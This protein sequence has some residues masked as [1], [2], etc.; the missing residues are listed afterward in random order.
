MRRDSPTRA[1]SPARA[2]ATVAATAPE[3]AREAAGAAGARIPPVTA[4]DKAAAAVALASP[5]LRTVVAGDGDDGCESSSFV[6][7]G[8]DVA[9]D[10]GPFIANNL[11]DSSHPTPGRSVIRGVPPRVAGPASDVGV[12]GRGRRERTPS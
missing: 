12:E 7:V 11:R 5:S 3:S 9:N 10:D 6:V 4:A 8:G 2:C 1:N